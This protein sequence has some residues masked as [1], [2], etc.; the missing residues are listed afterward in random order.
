MQLPSPRQRAFF[1]QAAESYHQ[2]LAGDT[3]AQAYLTSRGIGPDAASSFRLGVV[4]EPLVGHESY[5]GRLSIP[6]ITPA[7]V[8][9]F[10][11]R[12]IQQH[13]CSETVIG[14]A[15]DDKPIHCPKYLN[16]SLETTLYNVLDLGT[17]SQTIHICEGEL[18]ALTLSMAG[19]PAVGAPGVKSWKPWHT[20][21]LA[22]FAE[23]FV[24]ADSDQ[25][26]RQFA[27]F[28]EKELRARRVALPKG[29]DVN[30]VYVNAGADGLRGLLAR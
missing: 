12:C 25:A 2:Q 22:D 8:V 9:N 13:K 28:I 26:G 30:S 29:E 16:T 20:L 7:G 5:T 3:A 10:T 11:F 27:K 15:R 24:W 19:L 17:K 6:Y 14:M 1:E 21:C 23:V 4:R 18:D